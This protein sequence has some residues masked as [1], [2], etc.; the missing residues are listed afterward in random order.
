MTTP[1][2]VELDARLLAL[3]A[4]AIMRKRGVVFEHFMLLVVLEPAQ[5]GAS[6]GQQTSGGKLPGDPVQSR[7][8]CCSTFKPRLSRRAGSSAQIR[9][10]SSG[11]AS[12]QAAIS[13]RDRAQP[14]QKPV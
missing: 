4:V 9:S 3:G 13:A 11:D 14:E 2:R 7:V 8:A 10:R 5:P 12:R 1:A 6:G